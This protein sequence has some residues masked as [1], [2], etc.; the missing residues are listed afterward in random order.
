MLGRAART[1]GGEKRRYRKGS[2]LPERGE[3]KM[4]RLLYLVQREEGEDLDSREG[5]E[6]ASALFRKKEDLTFPL[7]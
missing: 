3:K 1:E 2:L 4:R 5:E 7:P 6:P